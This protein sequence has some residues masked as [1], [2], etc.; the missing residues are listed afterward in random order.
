MPQLLWTQ[1][2][3]IGPASRSDCAMAFDEERTK[4]VLFGGSSLDRGTWEWDGQYWTQVSDIGPPPRR[5]AGMVWDSARK[6]ILLFGGRR[7][8]PEGEQGD[9]VA[10]GDTWQ[11]K[12]QNWTQLDNAGPPA[13]FAFAFASDR[14]R[15]RII[16]FGGNTVGEGAPQAFGDTWEWDANGWSQVEEAGPVARGG[17]CMSFDGG[18]EQTVLFGG[19]TIDGTVQADTWE[20]SGEVWKHVAGFGPNRRLMSSMVFDGS[21]SILFGGQATAGADLLNDTWSWD[22]KF[23]TQRQ[24]IGPAPRAAHVMAFDTLRKKTVLFGGGGPLG[25][26][27]DTWELSERP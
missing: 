11:W 17:H 14:A 26:F 2:Q 3:N 12:G 9:I 1:R 19:M 25:T 27:G 16:L 20:W 4:V 15:N 7:V 13:R 24:D 10:L 23:W 5:N 6:C 18:R 22:G 8:G 21:Q